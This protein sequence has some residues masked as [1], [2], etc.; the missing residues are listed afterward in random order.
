M[1]GGIGRFKLSSTAISGGTVWIAT[2]SEI[3]SLPRWQTAFGDE[4]KDRRFYELLEDTLEG[5]D[6]G[7]LVAGSGDDVC[8]VQPYFIVDQDLAAGTGG[9]AKSIIAG[10]RR[11]W[12]RFMRA[13]TLMVGCAAGE[14]HLDG[15]EMVQSATAELLAGS[16]RRVARD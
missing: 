9:H 6:Y 15:G 16:L 4:R 12:P 8:A 14:G 5:F 10:I 2:R 11:L 7:Y 13:R 1:H 3:A